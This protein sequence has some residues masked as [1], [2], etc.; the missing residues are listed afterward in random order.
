[1]IGKRFGKY[2]I[3]A[4]LG[5]GGMGIVYRATHVTLNRTVALKAIF[6]HLAASG[7]YLAR[8]R[9][10]AITLARVQH[11][12]IVN[13]YDVEEFEGLSCIVMEYVGGSSLTRVLTDERRL[14]PARVR[15]IGC[16]LCSALAVAHRQGVIHRDIK[17]DNI[18]F[19]TDGRP[20]LTDFGIAHMR[21]D[22]MQTRTGIML[23]TPY[24]MSPEQARG[25]TVTAA[26]DLYSLGVVL[27]EALAGHV[28]FAAAD[29][30]A[31]ALMH[32]QEPPPPLSRVAPWVP[33]GIGELVH[34]MLEKDPARRFTN[35]QDL[36]TS[37]AAVSLAGGASPQTV[38]TFTSACPE[39]AA[40][41]RDDFLTCPRC[42][43]AIRQRCGECGRLHDPLSPEC[44]FCRTPATP[45][46]Q[47]ALTALPLAGIAAPV[48]ER[49]ADAIEKL[50]QALEKI[51]PPPSR[52]AIRRALQG[53]QSQL[54]RIHVSQLSPV[55]WVGIGL[56]VLALIGVAA[57]SGGGQSGTGPLAAD[58]TSGGGSGGL[59]SGFTSMTGG[60]EGAAVLRTGAGE[61]T[62]AEREEAGRILGAL[63]GP[64]SAAAPADSSEQT[65]AAPG[66]SSPT[67]SQ[68]E[69]SHAAAHADE[70]EMP[71]APAPVEET[72]AEARAAIEAIVE[73]QRRGTESGDI[74][75][76]LR[77]VATPLHDAV[78]RNFQAMLATTRDVTSRIT[79]VEVEFE[80]AALASVS[81]HAVLEGT[82][83]RD[84]RSVKIHD[85]RVRWTV[86]R[87]AGR[88][89]IVSID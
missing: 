11:E 37:L 30:L 83:I 67:E 73:R 12:N 80:D 29:S 5:R 89:Q 16:S 84:D 86:E 57:L 26:S 35:A 77:D 38:Q 43:L 58:S 20:K 49:V 41:I 18:L 48:I 42:A 2:L 60:Q 87:S 21:D 79:D 4:E 66:Q 81:F 14:D 23:G 36:A 50:P 15:D 45:T 10:E 33:P 25:R 7:E 19:T 85:G 59:A 72:E 31:V 22:Q 54:A 34:R 44:P 68:D 6:P 63:L 47:P 71:S 9:R 40:V 53:V 88:W 32:V 55:V 3:T 1:M 17:P 74:E 46:P 13:I 51:P 28:P 65:S 82:R 69:S 56:I 61:M 78:Q 52:T 24:Y 75:M 27:Y 70:K 62:A 76:L 39:C 8:F 64:D